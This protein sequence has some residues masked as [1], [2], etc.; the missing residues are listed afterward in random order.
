M[1]KGHLKDYI[2]KVHRNVYEQKQ[3]RRIWNKHLVNILTNKMDFIQSKYDEYLFYRGQTVYVLYMDD[4]ILA[5]P[6]SREIEGIIQ[7]IK[8]HK[9]DITI[10]G[11]VNDFLGVNITKMKDGKLHVSQPYF[12]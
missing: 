3:A 9:L 10:L 6:D 1:S 11:D 5:R 8:S 12:I 7:K 4:S 2:L